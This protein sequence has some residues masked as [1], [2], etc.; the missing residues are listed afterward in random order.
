MDDE[1]IYGV[2]VRSLQR[3]LSNIAIRANWLSQ[4]TRSNQFSVGVVSR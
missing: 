2:I 1:L 4:W 3:R